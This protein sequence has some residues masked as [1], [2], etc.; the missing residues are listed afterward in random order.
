MS[1]CVL[2]LGARGWY[3]GQCGNKSLEGPGRSPPSSAIKE[4]PS[5]LPRPLRAVMVIH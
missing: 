5:W 3:R 4:T 1:R 2:G